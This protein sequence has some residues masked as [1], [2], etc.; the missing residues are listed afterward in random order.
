MPRRA[1]AAALALVLAAGPLHG[2]GGPLSIVTTTTDL[3]ALV[4]AVGGDRVA[5]ESLAPPLVDPHA[6]EIK[7]GQLTR[8]RRSARCWCA[9]AWITSRGC[10]GR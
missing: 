2:A 8:L 3:K 5:V 1:C 4:E 10:A 7:P 6:V 9:S